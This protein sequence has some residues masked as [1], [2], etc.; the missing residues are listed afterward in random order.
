MERKLKVT[1]IKN[2][3][4][5]CPIASHAGAWR[6]P[7]NVCLGGQLMAFASTVVFLF[8][9]FLSFFLFFF[10][11]FLDMKMDLVLFVYDEGESRNYIELCLQFTQTV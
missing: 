10:L 8:F 7:K 3:E 4:V 11:P 6:T 1:T 2:I 9:F 5:R